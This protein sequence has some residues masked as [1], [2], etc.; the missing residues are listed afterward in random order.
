M[1]PIFKITLA[2]ALAIS[3]LGARADAVT[4]WNTKAGDFITEAKIGTPPAVRIMAIAQ[5]AVAD[6]ARAAQG[7]GAS[8]DAAI[9][10]AN[11]TVL[12]KFIPT[13]QAAI[14]T[15]Y[16]AALANVA[17][18]TAR[19]SGIELGEK[20][21]T[22]VIAARAD[23]QAAAAASDRYRPHAA[24]GAY[25]PTAAPAVTQ[26]P[27]RKP[28]LMTKADQFRPEP[29]P[30]L[31]SATWTRDYNEIKAIGSKTSTVRTAEQTEMARFWEYSLPAIY[32]G[33]LRSVAQMPGRSAAQNARLFAA[34]SQA[35][36]D[37]L[38]AVFD[39]KY[40]YNFWRPT[41]AVRNGEFDGNPATEGDTGWSSLIDA[42]L[43]PEYPSAHS[44]LAAAVGAVLQAELG[45]APTPTLTTTSPTAKG[46]A[47][48]WTKV[49]DFV[50]EVG[51]ARIY[52]GIHF[53]TSTEVGAK[54]GKQV[55]ELAAQRFARPD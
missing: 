16:Q 3:A 39:A 37:G 14:E 25:V 45:S 8:V 7:A 29:P 53:R 54:M 44:I 4:D 5:T 34:A 13:Q 43:H 55:G 12:L 18:G 52:E 31:N 2:A 46:A 30:A 10:A 19:T 49:D 26:W 1:K 11:R 32:N 35:M 51:N 6:G 41:T 24:P 48:S 33:V 38:I 17:Q 23:D 28:W 9:A 22:A 42:P 15:A 27:Q 47:R 40:Y 50:K 21:A 20:A 36:D